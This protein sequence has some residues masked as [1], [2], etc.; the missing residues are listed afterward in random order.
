MLSL[1]WLGFIVAITSAG[2][3]AQI[4]RNRGKVAQ[5]RLLKMEEM[6]HRSEIHN[7]ILIQDIETYTKYVLPKTERSYDVVVMFNLEKE[8]QKKRCKEC[9]IAEEQYN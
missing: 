5:T 6:D 7:V 8:D 4:T 2:E 1:L 9:I 3:S